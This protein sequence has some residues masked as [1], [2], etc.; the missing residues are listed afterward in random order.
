MPYNKCFYDCNKYLILKIIAGIPHLYF[1]KALLNPEIRQFELF[2]A[3]IN[4][5]LPVLKTAD[6][7]EH[8]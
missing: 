4:S 5:D 7:R 3:D 8:L 6:Q 2:L 1:I